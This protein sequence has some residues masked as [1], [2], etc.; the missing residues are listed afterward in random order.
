M[1]SIC[2]RY[3]EFLWCEKTV[4]IVCLLGFMYKSYLK[5]I[6]RM[7]FTMPMCL[8]RQ[9]LC[10]S[11]IKVDAFSMDYFALRRVWK[12]L[13]H[14]K[15]LIMMGAIMLWNLNWNVL[16]HFG[17]SKM[18]ANIRLDLSNVPGNDYTGRPRW[19]HKNGSN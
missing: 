11:K 19:Y 12:L 15:N 14:N 17:I 8:S 6:S 2:Y 13:L 10:I 16:H 9:T 18:I 3:L 7:V 1:V 5:G 4:C